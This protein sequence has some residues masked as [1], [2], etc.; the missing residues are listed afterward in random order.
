VRN[1]R[2]SLNPKLDIL[3]I[4]AKQI[5]VNNP[6]TIHQINNVL[7]LSSESKEEISFIDG[8]TANIYYAEINPGPKKIQAFSIRS[9]GQSTREL[10]RQ[11]I[12]FVPVIKIDAF[13]F[14]LRKLTE[15]GVQNIIPTVFQRSQKNNLDKITNAIQSSRLA[16][17]TQEAVK[18][19]EGAVFPQIS[20]P[21][22]FSEIEAQVSKQTSTIS[23]FASE[24]LADE[25][26]SENRERANNA[27]ISQ[28]RSSY[29]LLVGPEGGLTDEECLDLNRWGFHPISLGKRLLKAETAAI[30]LF[31]Y[32]RIN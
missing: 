12:F 16:K 25:G 17:I 32:L 31:S 23:I 24:R 8:L 27:E 10:E 30:S 7:R 21:I 6:D 26:I 18:Q 20:Q 9:I 13:E 2:F 22:K 1:Y 28:V 14:M 5:V 4:N 19:C 29:N 3:D 11:I 15:L